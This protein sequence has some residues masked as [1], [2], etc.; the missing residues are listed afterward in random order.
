MIRPSRNIQTNPSSSDPPPN[1][2]VFAG[3]FEIR[4]E[5]SFSMNDWCWCRLCFSIFPLKVPL[6][7]EDAI[8]RYHAVSSFNACWAKMLKL[9]PYAVNKRIASVSRTIGL[10]FLWSLSALK[11][12]LYSSLTNPLNKTWSFV[13][14]D[15]RLQHFTSNMTRQEQKKKTQTSFTPGIQTDLI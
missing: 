6:K 5:E 4:L 15:S 7:V 13:R 12:G 8:L 14:A 10:S 3:S 1:H 2:D 9:R 11:S